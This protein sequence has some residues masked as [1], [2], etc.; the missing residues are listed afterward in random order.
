MLRIRMSRLCSIATCRMFGLLVEHLCTIYGLHKRSVYNLIVRCTFWQHHSNVRDMVIRLLL[1]TFDQNKKSKSPTSII[2]QIRPTKS[3]LI[4]GVL[5]L[6]SV[7]NIHTG[8]CTT[9]DDGLGNH[10]SSQILILT[11]CPPATPTLLLIDHLPAKYPFM[12]RMVY[13]PE[14]ILENSHLDNNSP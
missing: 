14:H 4:F 3:Y 2:I 8:D 9:Y 12:H 1:Q 13:V 10:L 6:A 5:H 7:S 11:R